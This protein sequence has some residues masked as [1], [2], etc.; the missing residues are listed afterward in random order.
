MMPVF[1]AGCRP[2][3][4]YLLSP[5]L[6]LLPA[7]LVFAAQPP[8]PAPEAALRS[9]DWKT[10]EAGYAALPA[11]QGARAVGLARLYLLTGRL[12]EAA[13]Q[14]AAAA[15]SPLRAEGLTLQGEVAW[16]SGSPSEAISFYR[17]AVAAAPDQLRARAFLGIALLETGKRTEGEAMLDRF[18]N[19]FNSGK[20][21][22]KNAEA[23]TFTAMAAWRLGAFQDAS[24]T[25]GRALEIDPGLHQA[26]L[27]W[28]DL[29]ALKH[30]VEEA[31]RCY[32][33]VLKL[34]PNHPRALASMAGLQASA[35]DHEK[36]EELVERALRNSPALPAALLVRARM[37][38][39]D[40][41]S[42]G[43]EEL[44][45]QVLAAQPS[46][47]EAMA[48]MG[49]SRH[50]LGDAAG[51][52]NWRARALAVRPNWSGFDYEVAELAARRHRY[53][54]AAALAKAGSK[55]D[56][57]NAAIL[58]TAG[59]NTLRLGA[60]HEA[61][62]LM[63]MQ[64]AFELDPFDVRA[65]N[66]LNLYEEVIAQD[67]L[68]EKI[69]P[70][71]YRF[72][73]EEA[74]VLR[75]VIPPLLERA[76]ASYIRDY[77]FTPNSAVTVELFK[78]REHYGARTTGLP[79]IGAQGVCFGALI[80]AMSPSSGEANWQQVLWH[81]LAH[82]FHLQ[83]TRG[84]APR[85]FT[86]G[87][88]EYECFREN[89]AWRREQTAELMSL[90][91]SNELDRIEQ[92]SASFTRPARPDGVLLAYHQ[93]S[94]TVRWLAESYGYPALVRALRLYGEGRPDSQVLAEV[95]GRPLSELNQL[96]AAYLRKQFPY[97]VEAWRPDMQQARLPQA[98]ERAGREP[99]SAEA[100]A[101]LALAL[102]TSREGSV[103]AA[104]LEQAR[105][106]AALAPTSRLAAYALARAALEAKQP[107]EAVKAI[108]TAIGAE[109]DGYPL[110]LLLATAYL[111]QQQWPEAQVQLARAAELEPEAAE[112]AA[113]LLELAERQE[114]RKLLLQQH[115]RL[116][117]LLEHD[118]ENARLAVQRALTDSAWESL[119]LIAP[120]AIA[121]QPFDPFVHQAYGRAL[122]ERGA[123]KEAAQQFE[124]A[125]IAGA[126]PESGARGWWALA[127]LSAGNRDAAREQAAKALQEKPGDPQAARVMKETEKQPAPGPRQP[128]PRTP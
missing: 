87:L 61:E 98:Q 122:L 102:L 32:A 66:M 34:N 106:A 121:I 18:F 123:P 43:A 73:K 8:A 115:L 90:L 100:Q 59:L 83:M 103:R 104:A 35:G 68:T 20:I 72:P 94:L 74:P 125:L 126:K 53:A 71:V 58:A 76:W 70:F 1:F 9:G 38:L 65:F 46:S 118:W 50:L 89:P 97:Y 86:E 2:A 108:Q 79:E 92:L 3:M 22:Q 21:D 27:E 51:R 112:P 60:E 64:K 4:Q 119:L 99:A 111:H 69:G 52:D 49:A 128:G 14:A 28:G 107:E 113:L 127:L 29:F 25:F 88:S 45:Q 84:R 33:A 17:K 56:E 57:K 36:A 23:L 5:S 95:T 93:A 39:D 15:A 117:D 62:G 48:L 10:A 6:L 114:D 80:T 110:R 67:Y 42:Q 63:L 85:W 16:A 91:A 11:A 81:E 78:E 41:V 105:K 30:N 120:R 47:V 124:T 37:R 31:A 24:D 82:V 54:E 44:L 12:A 101:Y 109:Q 19:D 55:L 40:E 116:L 13:R 7:A 96:F 75:R 77:G 26:N